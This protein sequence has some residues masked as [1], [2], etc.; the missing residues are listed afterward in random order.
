[1]PRCCIPG[2]KFPL[3][4][5]DDAL[6]PEE[7]RTTF[8]F[9]SVPA[10]ALVQLQADEDA[11]PKHA[12]KLASEFLSRHC[13]G[14]TNLLDPDSGQPIPFTPDTLGEYLDRAETF[15]LLWKFSLGPE[16]KKKSA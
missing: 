11:E 15:E 7:R 2:F 10:T 6:L 13:V 5:D 16:D 14:W 12:L 9:R 8:Y 3:V 4:L 1:M